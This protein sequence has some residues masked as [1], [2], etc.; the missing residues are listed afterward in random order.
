MTINGT[1]GAFGVTQGP[2]CGN[3][4]ASYPNI[5]YGCSF[6][7]CS[8]GSA[9]PAAVSALSCVTSSWNFS[10]GGN[11]ATD[12]WDVAYDIWFCPTHTCGGSG[13][14]GGTELMIWLNY[15]NT[16]GWQN[17]LGTASLSGSSWEV[18]QATQGSGANSWN[19]LAYLADAQTSSVS[20]LNL[21]AFFQDALSRGYIQ[22][23]WYLYAVQAGDEIRSGG[24]PF[25]A[26]A[27]RFP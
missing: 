8:P 11:P 6:G 21:M 24:R 22:N 16:A 1:T 18:W 3:T 2:N 26:T 23:S 12:A 20:N 10:V 7:E 14:A 13:F 19:Y 4:V 15:N 5:L 9:L 17:H 25:T 27:S